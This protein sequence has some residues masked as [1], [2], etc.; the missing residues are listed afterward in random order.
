MGIPGP[1]GSSLHAAR[2]RNGKTDLERN[3]TGGLLRWPTRMTEF[4]AGVIFRSSRIAGEP[5][6]PRAAQLPVR[7]G[8]RRAAQ[9]GLHGDLEGACDSGSML[10]SGVNVEQRTRH[11][12]AR[13]AEVIEDDGRRNFGE[14][15]LA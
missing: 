13:V 15:V 3:T 5:G 14:G 4:R 1:L 8:D 12:A 9:A 11:A 7:C 6:S 10:S 2:R